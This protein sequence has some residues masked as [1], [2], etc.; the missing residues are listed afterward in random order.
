MQDWA[1]C[2]AREHIHI[3]YLIDEQTVKQTKARQTL[4]QEPIFPWFPWL[5][6]KIALPK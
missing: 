2:N 3:T 1:T 5:L 6:V 4:P